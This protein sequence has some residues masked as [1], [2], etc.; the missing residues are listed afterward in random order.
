MVTDKERRRA[1]AAAD[2][3][4]ALMNLKAAVHFGF[5]SEQE[6]VELMSLKFSESRGK[7]KE[8]R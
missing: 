3:E 5:I 8:D 4:I 2:T 6:G 1:R 7:E